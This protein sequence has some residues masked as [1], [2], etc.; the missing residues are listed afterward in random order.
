MPPA[1]AHA[2]DWITE[3]EPLGAQ[4]APGCGQLALAQEVLSPRYTP[5]AAAHADEA[6]C[7]QEPFAAQQ[8]PGVGQLAAAQVMPAPAQFPD[9]AVQAAAVSN[10]HVRVLGMQQAPGCG[11]VVVAQAVP[12]PRN[13]PPAA[14]HALAKPLLHE[15][16]GRQQ[17]PVTSGTIESTSPLWT[18][19]VL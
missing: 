1:V 10:T 6:V 3:H 15:P 13:T 9:A 7:E 2:L 16:S 4:Q 12:P 19:A 5:P 17:A 18:L 14:V 11:Q 8:A